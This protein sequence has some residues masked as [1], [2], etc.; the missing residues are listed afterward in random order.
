MLDL[1]ELRKELNYDPGTGKF[2]WKQEA[3]TLPSNGYRYITVQGKMM[4]AHRIAWFM[5]YGV[6][7]IGLIDHINGDRR[8]NRIENLRIATYSQNA[9]NAKRHSRN[10]SGLKGAS[11]VVKKGKRTSRW[12]SSITYQRRQISLGY[13]DTKE[14]AHAAY[15]MAAESLQG[16][17]ANDGLMKIMAHR[18]VDPSRVFPLGFGA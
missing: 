4:L 6:R 18:I 15:V 2:Y 1:E 14:E 12:Q 10:T 13:F 8:D 5:F 11:Q 3:G 16:K 9:A 17:F 7:P